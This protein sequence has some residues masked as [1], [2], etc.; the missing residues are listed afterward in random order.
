[1]TLPASPHAVI[2]LVIRE[3]LAADAG[4]AAFFDRIA[5]VERRQLR[6]PIVTP[7]LLVV[8]GT[9]TQV[10]EVGGAMD[11]TYSV[12]VLAVLPPETQWSPHLAALAAPTVTVS[13]SGSR[14]GVYRC[15]VTQADDLGESEAGAVAVSAAADSNRIT[16]T[17]PT[18]SSGATCW[19]VWA[20][21]AGRTGLRWAATLP[22][23]VTSW[24]DDGT[25]RADLA[26]VPF[27]AEDKLDD[28]QSVLLA[29]EVLS[30]GGLRYASA[31]MEC[32]T[33]GDE[34]VPVRNLRIR[35]LLVKI[36]T[37]VDPVTK[38]V[39]TERV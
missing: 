34:V 22:A 25:R 10:R 33:T 9:L 4:L 30:Y 7:S 29:N 2:P 8:P 17:R 39:Q 24:E 32:E 20:S 23:A 26:P 31:A 12:S 36:P 38:R 14:T 6:G 5:V 13:G 27:L 21:D 28:A 18:L 16:I 15:S 35:E 37:L 11:C 19:R 3:L 1:M